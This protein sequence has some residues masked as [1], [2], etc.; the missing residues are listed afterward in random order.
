M[1]FAKG[2]S[3]ESHGLK[4][5]DVIVNTSDEFIKVLDKDGVPF[6]VNLSDGY[7]GKEKSLPFAEGG[8]L[9]SVNIPE[10]AKKF[11]KSTSEVFEQI[12]IGEKHE[13]EH[14]K[15]PKKARKIALDHLSDDMDYYKKLKKLGL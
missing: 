3:L 9:K 12:Q 11:G 6:F 8:K 1:S 13:M 5:G 4:D 2:G 14:T 10:I 7:R 15:D